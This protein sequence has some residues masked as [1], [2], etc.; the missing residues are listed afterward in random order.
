MRDGRVKQTRRRQKDN[1]G[2]RVGRV[3]NK[4]KVAKHFELAIDKASF[5]YRI[6]QEE[7]R[8]GSRA[9]RAFNV[10]RMPFMRRR[11]QRPMWCAAISP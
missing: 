2:V 1:I 5:S 8:T 4:Y 6:N 3:I 7:G 11:L 9:R 10:L